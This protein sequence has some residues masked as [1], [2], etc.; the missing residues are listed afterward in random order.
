LERKTPESRFPGSKSEKSRKKLEKTPKKPE[1]TVEIWSKFGVRGGRKNTEKTRKN[2]Q[3][4]GYLITLPVGTPHWNS[5]HNFL[6]EMFRFLEKWFPGPKKP[7][8][9]G[10]R[11]PKK[12]EK[13]GQKSKIWGRKVEKTAEIR[14]FGA[15]SA[16][17]A[18][19]W[20]SGCRSGN[21]KK[22]G[23]NHFSRRHSVFRDNIRDFQATVPLKL[24]SSTTSKLGRQAAL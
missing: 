19:F 4:A 2:A 8:S 5:F 7:V 18:N 1:K 15:K 9:G 12:P 10:P 3:F 22:L 6:Q 17:S 20:R 14:G 11:G 13:T 21:L 24:L 16:V 23:K